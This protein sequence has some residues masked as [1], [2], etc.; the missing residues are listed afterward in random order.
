MRRIEN[1]A[2]LA[3]GSELLGSSRLDSN[4]LEVTRALA[5][6]GIQVVEKR[7]VGDDEKHIAASLDDLLA[8]VDL[9]VVTGGLGPTADDVTR[10][11]AARAFGRRLVE[12]AQL[13]SR[14]EDRF[15]RVGRR[16]PEL[17]RR[18]ALVVEG[19]TVLANVNGAAPGMVLVR[20]DGGTVVLLPGVSWEMRAMLEGEVLPLL[21][22][23]CA[24]GVRLERTLVLT[25]ALESAVE[26][27]VRPLYERFG[28]EMVTILAATGVVRLVLTAAGEPAAASARLEEMT[29]AFSEAA[30][31]DLAGT[32]VEGPAEAVLDLLRRQGATLA[33]AESCTGGLVGALLTQVPGASDV[34]LGGVVSYSNLAKADLLGVPEPLLAEHGAVS[35][36]VARAMARGARARLGADWGLAIT[37]VAGPSGGTP[38]KPVG[39]VHWAAAGP[40]GEWH[41]SRVFPGDR[42]AVR[43]WSATMAIDLVRRA[44]AGQLQ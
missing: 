34:Y 14:L 18:M 5:G 2:C 35:E 43:R 40:A 24:G 12:D 32:D 16:M 19:A 3:V 37:G 29:A 21:R 11:G 31:D 9:V 15:R 25:G 10:E 33:T 41:G 30:G 36:A 4:S 27:R 13:V 44:A 7:V 23:R 26:E 28:R 6:C 38:E 8:R 42:D 39:L 1:A 20:E 22:E 17:A